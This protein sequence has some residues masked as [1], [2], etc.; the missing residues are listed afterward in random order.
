MQL[1]VSSAIVAAGIGSVAGGWLADRLGRR[2]ALLVADVLFTA[3]AVAMA[4]APD[5][6]WLVAGGL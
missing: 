5:Q 4:A 1:I 6:Y 3:G 2:A